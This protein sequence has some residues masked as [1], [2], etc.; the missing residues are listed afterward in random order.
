M[1]QVKKGSRVSVVYTGK[2]KDGTVFETNIGQAPLVFVVGKGK[3][4][5]GFENAVIGMKLGQTKT[6][7]FKPSDAYG[8]K[9][10]ALI[11]TVRVDEIP[12]GTN[13]QIDREIS[14]SAKDGSLI[15]GVITKIDG[16]EIT[17]DGNH[18]LAGRSLTFEIKIADLK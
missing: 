8:P 17:V 12:A 9:D 11:S 4:I 10:P 2:F 16:E 14:F 5:K 7:V 6:A 13:L 1:S 3:V 15:E 18:P